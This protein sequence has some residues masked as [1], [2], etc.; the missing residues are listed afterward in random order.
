MEQATK[1][2]SF[3]QVAAIAETL[4]NKGE[5]PTLRGIRSTLGTGSLGTIQKHLSAW[6]ANHRPLAPS[7]T[8]LPATIQNAILIEIER[9]VNDARV[10]MEVELTTT[11][12]DRDA[13]AEDNEQ[14]SREI[15]IQKSRFE[16]L[17]IQ[18][19]QLM[20]RIDQLESDNNRLRSELDTERLKKVDA[21]QQAAILAEKLAGMEIRLKEAQ[22][23]EQTANDTLYDCMNA[24][25]NKDKTPSNPASKAKKPKA[26]S[27]IDGI[28]PHT[29]EQEP[30]PA[31]G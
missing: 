9:N 7:N 23:R 28:K 17:Q 14:Q 16:E 19:H 5:R 31:T 27:N 12:A 21:N 13:L 2:I 25:S 29:K 4:T 8:A 26:T 30:R 15:D 10:E 11:K 22:K 6:Q 20:G 1:G 3:E 24:F 18:M